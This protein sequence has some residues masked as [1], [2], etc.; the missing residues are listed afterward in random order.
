M[1]S[2]VLLGIKGAI[3]EVLDLVYS[4]SLFQRDEVDFCCVFPYCGF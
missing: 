4:F 2:G 1:F 3:E